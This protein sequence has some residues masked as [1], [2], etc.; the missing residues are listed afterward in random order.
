MIRQRDIKVKVGE[1]DQALTGFAG[2]GL[3]VRVAERTGLLSL[4]GISLISPRKE[5]YQT[6]LPEPPDNS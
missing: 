4:R 5:L 6:S 3:L 1:T 2:A